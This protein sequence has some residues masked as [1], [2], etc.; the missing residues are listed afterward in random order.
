MLLRPWHVGDVIRKLREQHDLTTAA[1]A[2]TADVK[3]AV[4]KALER[5]G[6]EVEDVTPTQWC[7]L[8]PEAPSP[9]LRK[10]DRNPVKVPSSRMISLANR[11]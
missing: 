5:G 2:K 8:I 3:T 1:L 6:P 10:S 9:R 4:I 7:A 11:K